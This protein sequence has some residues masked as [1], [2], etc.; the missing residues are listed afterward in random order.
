MAGAA[1]QDTWSL[2]GDAVSDFNGV[3]FGIQGAYVDGDYTNTDATLAIAGKVGSTWG[4]FDAQLI[5]SYINDGDYSLMMAGTKLEDSALWTDNEDN[6]DIIHHAVGDSQGQSAV[7]VQAGYKLPFGKVY[8]SL[9]YWDYDNVKNGYLDN[10]FGARA[11]YKFNVAGVDT[12]VEYRY[13]DRE[14]KNA[15]DETRQR[16]RVE[17]YYKF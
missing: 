9:G 14:Y 7:L 12:K 1:A 5:A 13:R 4:N 11:G 6:A 15:K 8:G 17:A 2:W 10:T 3:T 16:I